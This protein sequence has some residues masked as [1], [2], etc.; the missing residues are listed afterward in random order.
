MAAPEEH[1]KSVNQTR[2]VL[3]P[4]GSAMPLGFFAFG[5]GALM[6]A[7]WDLHWV[8]QAQYKPAALAL[9]AFVMPLELLACIFSFLSR[10]A[11]GATAMGIFSATWGVFAIFW[12]VIGPV[13]SPILGIFAIMV[14][15][16][17]VCLAATA[18]NAKPLLSILLAISAVR[19]A[20]LAAFHLGATALLQA[21]GWCGLILAAFAL[22]GGVA[23]LMEDVNQR[24]ILPILRRGAA[25]TSLEGNLSDQLRRIEQEA[26]VRNQL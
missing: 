19:D 7:V 14:T 18:W 2:I 9:L 17:V 16:A 13:Q 3:R 8:A 22:Y 1:E 12:L 4:L 25:R 11:A 15:A 21:V 5:A 10:D 6:T 23:F 24:T 20:S 26:G